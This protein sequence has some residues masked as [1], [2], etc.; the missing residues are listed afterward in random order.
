MTL[1]DPGTRGIE[2]P[3]PD[4][5]PDELVARAAALRQP[6]RERQAECERLGRLPDAT[7][8]DFIDAGFWRA[9]Q[10]R[11]FGGYEFDLVTFHQIAKELSRGCPSSGWVYALT[12][13]HNLLVG[14]FPEQAQVELFGDGDFRCPLAAMAAPV[15]K[16]DGG[17]HV[18]GWWDYASGC[19]AATHFIGTAAILS[20]AGELVDTRWFAVRRDQFEI[21]DNWDTLGMRGTGSRR[22]VIKDVFVPEHHTVPCFNPMRP[23][24][25]LPGRNVHPNPIYR[26][27]GPILP[28]LVSEVVAL[29]VGIAQGAV[30]EYIEILSGRHQWGP[31]SPLRRDL[32][33]FQRLL[34][35][36]TAYTDTAEATLAEIARIWTRYAERA[37]DGAPASD[38]EERRLLLVEQQ[39]IETCCR[40]VDLIFRTS[41]SSASNKGQRVE[42]YFRDLS[43]VRTHITLQYERTFENV[44]R[45]RLGLPPEM[46]V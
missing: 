14:M 38:E 1:Q 22:V 10:P 11:R 21:I 45:M 39:A 26:G 4:L 46:P 2:P 24:V 15:E 3:E 33:V 18:N 19:D 41:G 20:E 30:D 40:A 12:A 17:Y 8:R 16:V 37:A 9:V 34:G 6:L 13:A 35:E 25:E 27:G 5:T 43:M 36:V 29:A 32:H 42:R 7:V 28:L 31:M 44:G 23:I